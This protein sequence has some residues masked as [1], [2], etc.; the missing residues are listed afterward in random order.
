[1]RRLSGTGGLQNLIVR[2]HHRPVGLPLC[3]NLGGLRLQGG[4]AT[5][6]R[7]LRH[8]GLALLLLLERIELGGEV[9]ANTV[10]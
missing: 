1:M 5:R 6:R 3:L 8:G 9:L 2:P 7:T 4:P 10:K